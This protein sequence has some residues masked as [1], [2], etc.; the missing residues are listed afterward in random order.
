MQ[1]PKHIL[2]RLTFKKLKN[3][4]DSFDQNTIDSIAY[5]PHP[6]KDC[7]VV[8]EREHHTKRMYVQPCDRPHWRIECM[9]CRLVYNCHT[10]QYD[11]DSKSVTDHFKALFRRNG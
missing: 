4:P 3:H 11:L 1:I 6:C 5:K 7:G 10:G 2:E 8:I 9:N